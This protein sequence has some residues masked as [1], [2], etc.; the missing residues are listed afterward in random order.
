MSY[1]LCDKLSPLA[2]RIVS[3]GLQE[4][5]DRF[6]VEWR[7]ASVL[8]DQL[9]FF[10]RKQLPKRRGTPA[11]Q[12]KRRIYTAFFKCRHIAKVKRIRPQFVVLLSPP[13]HPQKRSKFRLIQS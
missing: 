5:T 10:W 4:T 9:L 12:N 3:H 8:L 2:G 7:D 1:M 11:S 6:L 13:T